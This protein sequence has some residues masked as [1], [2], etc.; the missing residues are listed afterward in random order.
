MILKIANEL[1]A[2]WK[3]SSLFEMW[4]ESSLSWLKLS[5]RVKSKMCRL[6]S[7]DLIFHI[8]QMI[9]PAGSVKNIKPNLRS[10]A[11]LPGR[12]SF[13]GRGKMAARAYIIYVISFIAKWK[14]TGIPA[15]VTKEV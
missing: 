4:N 15:G 3:Y 2:L 12:T 10:A 1:I 5:S 14:I 6:N 9:I 7:R 8:S 11:Q 13:L